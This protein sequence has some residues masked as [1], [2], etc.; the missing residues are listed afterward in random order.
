MNYNASIVLISEPVREGYTFSGWQNV[1]ESMPA[2]DYVITGTFGINTYAVTWIVG[3][4]SRVDSLIYGSP[5]VA[6]IAIGTQVVT[7]DSIYTLIGWMPELA[8]TVTGD[9]TYIAVY[10]S[11]VRI[12]QVT[13]QYEDGTVILIDS[14][15][16]GT[17]PEYTGETPTK[18][19][20]GMYSYEFIGWIEPFVPVAGDQF[21]TAEFE[22]TVITSV[23]ETNNVKLVENGII[24]ATAEG[25][26][27]IYTI[28]G[29][30]VRTIDD[31]MYVSELNRG[32]YIIVGPT[33]TERLVIH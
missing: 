5:I 27:Y 26:V 33:H 13:W 14:V 22:A 30:L 23:D 3:D 7:V 1:I 12:Y 10:D 20:D 31:D 19:S 8:E 17:V 28:Q 18:A 9:V 16:Y 32:N 6:P 24:H 25:P 21:Y 11:E 2:S 29:H 15:A 4:T